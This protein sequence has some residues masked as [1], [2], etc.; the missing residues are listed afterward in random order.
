ME[1]EENG[2]QT[3]INI[4]GTQNVSVFRNHT[5]HT[6]ENIEFHCSMLNEVKF[7]FTLGRKMPL[8]VDII[9]LVIC[10]V[11][12]VGNLA[13]V[14]I[15]AINV[16]LR[17]PYFLTILTLAVADLFGIIFK[18]GTIFLEFEF[19]MY[20]KCVKSPF[21]I[22]VSTCSTIELNSILQVVLIAVIK[23]LLLVY[24]IESRAYVT[25]KLIAG[26]FFIIWFFSAI[27]TFLGTY[28][29]M[30]KV[31]ANEDPSTALM[32]LLVAYIIPSNLVIILLHFI[33]VAKLRKSQALQKEV[34]K[35]NKV[36][37]IIL[38][39]YLVHTFIKIFSPFIFMLSQN[40]ATLQFFAGGILVIG[41]IHHA[42]NPL[43]YA[44]F[45]PLVQRPWKR[46]KERVGKR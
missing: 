19:V 35:M 7:V 14:V 41:F 12:I 16:K 45:T 1:N 24:P 18:L 2:A 31:E 20:I 42:A 37:S 6:F 33:K 40:I 23:F 29:F 46:L 17:K 22:F 8:Y 9:C 25:N 15:V 32:G 13:T 10:V 5:F 30:K 38:G 27:S 4:N 11:G 39:I 21:Y 3:Q 36:V 43:I 26:L 34:Q 28:L 44:A